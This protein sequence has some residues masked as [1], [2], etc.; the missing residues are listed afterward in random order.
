MTYYVSSETLNSTHS[1]KTVE[2]TLAGTKENF[3]QYYETSVVKYTRHKMLLRNHDSYYWTTVNWERLKQLR[4]L[5]KSFW[6]L[7]DDTDSASTCTICN[8]YPVT[9][10]ADKLLVYAHKTRRPQFN[11][12]VWSTLDGKKPQH[13]QT[14][15][16]LNWRFS[17]TYIYIYIYILTTI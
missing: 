8:L 9:T 1:H 17:T 3:F 7:N 13:T 14:Q 15:R 11:T 5:A 4:S 10:K 6:M 16:S 2:T 12:M